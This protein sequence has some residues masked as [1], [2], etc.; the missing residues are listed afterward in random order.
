MTN[1]TSMLLLAA[2]VWGHGGIQRYMKMILRIAEVHHQPCDVLSVHDDVDTP[3]PDG[4]AYIGCCGSKWKYCFEALRFAVRGKARKII[5][6]HVGLLPVAWI[7]QMTRFTDEYTLVL[8][9]IEAWRRLGCIQRIAARRAKCIVAT[10]AYTAREF[11]YFNGIDRRRCSIVPLAGDIQARQF[12]RSAPERELQ[13]MT[14]SRLSA[15]DRYKGFDCLLASVRLGLDC[16]LP[17]TLQ[18]VGSGDDIERLR[19][20]A[21]SLG[22][23]N[24]LR[25]R[26]ALADAEL[27]QVYRESH[28]FVMPSKKEGFGIVYL[29]AMAAGLP[30]IGANHGGVPEVVEHRV[31]GDDQHGADDLQGHQLERAGPDQLQPRPGCRPGI[32]RHLGLHVQQHDRHDADLRG[33][34]EHE[35]DVHSRRYR[36]SEDPGRGARDVARI[37]PLI[38]SP[39]LGVDR[40]RLRARVRLRTFRTPAAAPA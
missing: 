17:L 5:V 20:I 22:I 27:E 19:G 12:N 33:V 13:L 21:N 10:T 37:R 39:F 32:R 25:F 6:G 38:R 8:H 15:A 1:R 24:A 11:C 9:G 2:E 28:V 31:L 36:L 29:E 16:G 23:Q 40:G 34:C 35:R 26:G 14:V 4:S 30:C 7:L 18:I 3:S